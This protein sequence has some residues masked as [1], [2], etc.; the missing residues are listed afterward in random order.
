MKLEKKIF[1]SGIIT[2]ISGLH[3]GGSNIGL[4]VGGADSIVIRNPI[5][6][7]PYIPG[8]SFKGKM[9]SLS[10]KLTGQL[11]AGGKPCDC[12]SCIICQLFGVGASGQKFQPMRLIVRDAVLT[13]ESAATLENN[14]NTDMEY[15]EI[16]TEVVIDRLSAKAN[17]RQIERVPAGIDFKFSLVLNTYSDD[18][19]KELLENLFNALSLVQDDYIGGGGSRGNG[20]V[21]IKVD[22]ILYKD[23]DTYENN[24]ELKEYD[25]EIPDSLKN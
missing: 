12:G 10:E 9:R 17:P 20:Q 23:K 3:I 19:E 14:E 22:S 18:N 24:V 5:N 2:T 7:E 16:K 6:F 1:I 11:A 8:S 13:N 15:T 21:N 4:E 25:V